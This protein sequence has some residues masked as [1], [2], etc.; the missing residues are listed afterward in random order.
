VSKRILSTAVNA[1]LGVARSA[2]NLLKQWLRNPIVVAVAKYGLG[3]ALLAYV[4]WSK[5]YPPP[6]SDAKGL[7]DVWNG[8]ISIQWLPLGIA[9]VILLVAVVLT[10]LRWWVLVVAQG[11]SFPLG[12]ALRL[13]LLG[14][15]WSTFFP[16]S[17]GGDA[18]K[19][20]LLAREQSR[21]TVAVATVLIDRMVGLWA[22]IWLV[23]ILGSAFWL[24]GSS[25][26]GE[27]RYLQSIVWTAGSIVA[28]SVVCWGLLGFLP[29]RR[30]ERFA[31]R[32]SGIPKVGH[33]LA[34][35]WR[36]VW[37]YRRQRVAIA[38]ALGLSLIG[39]V[40][41]VLSYYFSAMIFLG[42]DQRNQIPSVDVQFLLVPI[43]MAGQAVFPTPGGVGAGE[44]FLGWLYEQVGKSDRYGSLAC[45][46]QRIINWGLAFSG[47]LLCL[48]TRRASRTATEAGG[49]PTDAP[50]DLPVSEP[51]PKACAQQEMLPG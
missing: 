11:I 4:I 47:Y 45:L 35:F 5:W 7:V 48:W 27:S 38:I 34:E 14:Y 46:G 13:G 25:A 44:L 20:F 6:G 22:L 29:Q 43:A 50:A 10:F 33:S 8:N 2:F 17:I 32:L 16:G 49:E 36:A 28:A 23:A 19:A 21:R 51:F 40:G 37:L 9:A 26:I 24:S 31:G 42:F 15:F 3:F 18:V 12:Y 41:F 39:H 30:A 1:G